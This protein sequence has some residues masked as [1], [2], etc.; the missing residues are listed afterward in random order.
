MEVTVSFGKMLKKGLVFM[1]VPFPMIASPQVL[2][3]VAY[4]REGGTTCHLRLIF[5]FEESSSRS[6]FTVL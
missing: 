4:Y 5:L 3:L 1:G 2:V 6:A